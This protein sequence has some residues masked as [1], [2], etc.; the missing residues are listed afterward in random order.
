[1]AVRSPRYSAMSGRIK[2]AAELSRTQIRSAKQQPYGNN[3][4]RQMQPSRVAKLQPLPNPVDF[5]EWRDAIRENFPAI[6]KTA[7]ICASVVAKLLMNDVNNT[8]A[9]DVVDVISSSM[10][11]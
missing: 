9:F 2:R 4:A 3:G 11:N 10:T 1:M 8:F 6:V 7:E 5:N